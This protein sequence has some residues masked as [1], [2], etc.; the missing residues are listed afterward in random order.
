MSHDI[1]KL[2]NAESMATNMHATDFDVVADPRTG[3]LVII[4]ANKDASVALMFSIHPGEIRIM[5]RVA[6]R[7]LKNMRLAKHLGVD[8]QD[9][10]SP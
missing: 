6:D 9:A 4:C 5:Q 1:E 2:T 10:M 8:W 7:A 3:E